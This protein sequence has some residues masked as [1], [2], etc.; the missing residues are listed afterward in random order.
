MSTLAVALTGMSVTGEKQSAARVHWNEQRRARHQLFVI[1]ISRM[2]PRW[3]AADA[4]GNV[5]RRH[6][7]AAKERMQRISI[8]SAKRPIIRCWSNG[9]MRILG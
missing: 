9:M 7:D 4:A 2:D 8:P 1:Q 6:A 3:R 5:R